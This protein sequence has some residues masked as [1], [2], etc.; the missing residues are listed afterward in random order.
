MAPSYFRLF[1]LTFSN[2]QPSHLSKTSGR[3]GPS[4]H[5]AQQLVDQDSMAVA[6]GDVRPPKVSGD[7]PRHRGL[8]CHVEHTHGSH[9][10]IMGQSESCEAIWRRLCMVSYVGHALWSASK[11]ICI[12]RYF[13]KILSMFGGI[14]YQP[15]HVCMASIAYW[16]R[17]RLFLLSRSCIEMD[18]CSTCSVV[19]QR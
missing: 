12:I 10:P 4:Q 13:C 16:L 18:L 5:K 3:S 9:G 1:L 15:C 14:A 2:L 6:S 8:L 11:Y 17:F 19:F 7:L